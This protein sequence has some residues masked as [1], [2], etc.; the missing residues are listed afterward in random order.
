MTAITLAAAALSGVAVFFLYQWLAISNDVRSMSVTELVNAEILEQRRRRQRPALSDRWNA[1]L[2]EM[3][4]HERSLLPFAAWMV[5]YLVCYTVLT[6]LG[7]TGVIGLILSLF[8]AGFVVFIVISSMARRRHRAVNRQLVQMLDLVAGQ[9]ESGNGAVAAVETVASTM[10]EPMHTEMSAAL[11]ASGVSPDPMVAFQLL[12]Q[13]FPSR[14]IN[15]IV[16]AFEVNRDE[17]GQIAPAIRQAASSLRR[18]R[19][20]NEETVAE[21]AQS[22]G[23]FWAIIGLVGGITLMLVLSQDH[24]THH[25][26]TTGFGLIAILFG[27]ANFAVGIYRGLRIFTKARG[28]A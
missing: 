17:G 3:G 19:D 10:P 6:L 1:A 11:A 21:I 2:V 28:S 5:L 20:L 16:G 27:V 26:F 23:E 25:P 24:G 7:A 14:A 15:L 13:K 18:D 12:G 8:V 9:L 22:K 4:F